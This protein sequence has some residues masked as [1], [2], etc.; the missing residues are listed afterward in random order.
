MVSVPVDLKKLSDVVDKEVVKKDVYDELVK[1]VNAIQ[2]TDTSN[3]DK[4]ADYDTKIEELEKKIMITTHD[5][6]KY[7]TNQEFNKLTSENFSAGLKQANLANKNDIDDFVKNQILIMN[8]SKK[9]TL[10]NSWITKLFS[11]CSN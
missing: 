6:G 3:E 1:K 5:H 7:N 2:T 11:I 8:L 9:I 10:D 4:K